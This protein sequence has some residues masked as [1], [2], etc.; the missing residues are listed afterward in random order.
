MPDLSIRPAT[1]HDAIHIVALTDMAGEGLPALLWSQRAKPGESPIEIGRTRAMREEGAFS[2][3]NAR[4]A[5]RGGVIAGLVL[6]YPLI[7]GD[8]VSDV[9]PPLRGLVEL[10]VEAAGHW[11][12]NVLGVYPEFRSLGIGGRLLE[13]ADEI[14]SAASPEGMAIIVASAN[15]GARRLYERCGYRRAASRPAIPMPGG[16]PSTEWILLTKPHG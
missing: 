5:E 15:V 14:G 2:F 6:G 4:I 9:P 16:P 11:Y 10:E 13:T 3:R 12:V 7:G 8:D 1:S